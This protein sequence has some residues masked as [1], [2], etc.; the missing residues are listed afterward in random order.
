M[1]AGLEKKKNKLANEESLTL[2]HRELAIPAWY[3]LFF[4]S[5]TMRLVCT[6][7]PQASMQKFTQSG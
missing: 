3:Q 6:L 5:L 2:G 1:L 4:L 7:S